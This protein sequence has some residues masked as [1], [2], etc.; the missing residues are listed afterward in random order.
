MSSGGQPPPAAQPPAVKICGVRRLADARLCLRHQVDEIGINLYQ[1]SKRYIALAQA[2]AWLGGLAG[3]VRRVAVVVNE[4]LDALL[5]VWASGCFEALQLH[6]DE[7]P[8]LCR[9]LLERGIEVTKAFALAGP[10]TVDTIDGY[11][12]A[13]GILIDAH[14]AGE[15]G[16]TG[17]RADW[18]LAA[19]CAERHP[20]RRLTLSGGLAPDNVAAAVDRVRPHAVDVASGVESAPGVKDERMIEAFTRNARAAGNAA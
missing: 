5:R 11:P 3:S 4:P 16:G 20:R 9:Q 7:P 18:E 14:V 17:V 15:R 13:V 2:V 19:Y 1:R 10:A 8:E 6:G 12:A